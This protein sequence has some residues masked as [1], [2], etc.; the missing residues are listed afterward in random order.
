[1]CRASRLSGLH[2]GKCTCTFGMFS[3]HTWGH[4]SLEMWPNYMGLVPSLALCH[5]EGNF[6]SLNF[7]AS[8]ETRTS[9]FTHEHYL[10]FVAGFLEFVYIFICFSYL[11]SDVSDY[12]YP[13]PSVIVCMP[14]A[15]SYELF[16]TTDELLVWQPN[17]WFGPWP[18]LEGWSKLCFTYLPSICVI[19]RIR[20]EIV[21]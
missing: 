14:W 16:L 9:I 8:R 19:V 11:K 20:H 1:M 3:N 18:M 2:L 12:I 13:Q 5:S 17:A 7:E 6:L 15:A 21:K 10:L 4:I